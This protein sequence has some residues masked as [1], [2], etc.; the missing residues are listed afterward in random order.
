MSDSM[1]PEVPDERHEPHQ[2]PEPDKAGEH[3]EGGDGDGAETFAVSQSSERDAALAAVLREQ[4]EKEEFQEVERA[5]R[6]RRQGFGSRHLALAVAVVLSAW[7]WVW[8]PA[9]IR[10]PSPTPLPLEEEEATLRLVM[11]FQAQR[12]EQYFRDT[13]GVPLALDEAGP[14]FQ[15]M[16]YIRL[17]N[18]DYRILGR[19]GRV[20]LSYSSAE[21]LTVF[22]GEGASI[23]NV[24]TFR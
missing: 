10:I 13:G 15:G 1:D 9:I 20:T 18:R 2:A 22:V 6:V 12:I 17:T 5:V 19:T 14:V 8:P 24:R 4:T 23:L 3:P 7:I 21:P 16:E 11:Y